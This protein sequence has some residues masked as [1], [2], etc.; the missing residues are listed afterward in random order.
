M[1]C[2]AEPCAKSLRTATPKRKNSAEDPRCFASYRAG[3]CSRLISV[4]AATTPNTSE[5]QGVGW[6]HWAESLAQMAA[7]LVG[8]LA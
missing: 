6:C 1:H 2:C 4:V 3:V 8:L 7:A 5:R